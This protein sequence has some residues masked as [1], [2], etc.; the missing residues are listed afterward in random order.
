M[1]NDIIYHYC[2]LTYA[3]SILAD[4]ELRP[5]TDGIGARERPALW[6]TPRPTY[7]PT[8]VKMYKSPSTGL[9]RQLTLDEQADRFGLARFAV[10]AS[11]AP[12]DWGAWVRLSRVRTADA[13]RMARQAR[14]LGSDISLYR[15]TFDAVPVDRCV[16]I[17]TSVDGRIW[18]P[19]RVAAPLG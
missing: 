13:K 2:P 7:E 14:D 18:A 3:R 15:A 10:P 6:F 5:S 9:V 1:T 11:V 8:A 17:E 16:D 4:G 19:L 12:H